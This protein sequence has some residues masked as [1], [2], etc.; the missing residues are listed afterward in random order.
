MGASGESPPRWEH[1]HR[2]LQRARG[3][4]RLLPWAAGSALLG[5]AFLSFAARSLSGGLPLLVGGLCLAAFIA[6]L[7][8]PRCPSCG[9]NLWR[10]GERP[11]PPTSPRP[12][13]VER[14]RRCPRCGSAFAG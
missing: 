11:G 3:A 9:G 13:R 10:A 6:A 7:S 4:R 8:Y 2:E 14:E 12:T 1:V 5:Y